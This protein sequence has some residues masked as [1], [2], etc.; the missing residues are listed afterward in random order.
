MPPLKSIVK[1]NRNMSKLR[2]GRSFWASAYASIAEIT[3]LTTVP[4]AVTII[5]TK[6]P[7]PIISH[8]PKTYL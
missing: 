7:F 5:V 1:V 4:T 8:W 6:Y 2:P 3:T